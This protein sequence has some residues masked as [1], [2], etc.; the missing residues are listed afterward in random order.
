MIIS[1]VLF[2]RA[3]KNNDAAESIAVIDGER[4]FTYSR[5][6]RFV[7]SFCSILEKNGVRK[8]DTVAIYLPN[9]VEFIIGFFALS[10]IGAVSLP[11]NVVNRE[12]ELEYY[13]NSTGT[14][15]LITNE[16]YLPGLSDL[17]SG[18]GL[19]TILI[20]V[21]D[22]SKS[23]DRDIFLNNSKNENFDENG[24]ALYLFS[25]GSTGKPKCISRTHK[26]LLTLAENHTSTAGWDEKDG[27]LMA[28]PMSH[29]YGFG[30]FISAIRAGATLFTIKD[31]NRKEIISLLGSG[32]IT[33]FPAVPFM[34]DILSKSRSSS[35]NDY[36]SLKL[37]FSAG[38]PLPENVFYEFYNKF[39]IYPRQLYG[40]SETGVISIN[41]SP[42]IK[43]MYKSVG[44]P[45][46]NVTV[47][48]VNDEGND[49]TSGHEGEIIV[50]SPSM[51]Y[52]YE[53]SAEESEKSFR[54]GFYYTGDIGFIDENG[55]IF[56]N[57]RKKLFINIAGYKV[58]PVEVEEFLLRNKDIK[59]V[60]VKGV[61]N[62]SEQE[63][64]KAFIVPKREMKYGD[65]VE[66]CRGRIS[67]YKI[68]GIVEFRNS[69]PKSP[70]GKVLRTK[71]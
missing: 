63:V 53:N 69:L 45:V 52:R 15:F 40:S 5:I 31:F 46:R 18:F 47:K 20:N 38:A 50:K 7:D 23:N 48:I 11:L 27:V 1:D 33:N 16:N 57:G 3:A 10:M 67:E 30:N 22:I 62:E 66:F 34:L 64:V 24:V 4:P 42:E 36:R 39:G 19:R 59:E 56:I 55:Y 28:V 51:T 43:K 14:K 49:L 44:R 8:N 25:T 35:V 12:T 9:S 13:I 21:D 37:V 58:D 2:K 60:A 29:T 41:M 70:T 32:K 17:R 68:P 26:N 6:C 65:I 54:N 71:L 61:L